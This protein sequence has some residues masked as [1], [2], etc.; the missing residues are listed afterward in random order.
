M[1]KLVPISLGLLIV[2]LCL[3]LQLTT[4]PQIM[5]W[6]HHLANLTYDTQIKFNHWKIDPAK[7]P[8]AIVAID[9]KSLKTIGRWPWDRK[10]L[11]KL[12]DTLYKS[13]AVAV[14]F[15]VVFSEPETN[16]AL[17]IANILEQ[18]NANPL[19]VSSVKQLSPQLAGD[20][21]LGKSLKGGDSILGYIFHA[22]PAAVQNQLPAPLLVLPNNMSNNSIRRM[23]YYSSNI[24]LLQQAAA[25]NGFI[26]VY[27]DPDGIIRRVP[28]LIEHELAL[29]PSLSLAA[30][31]T[32]LLSGVKINW[33]KVGDTW[34]I[35]TVQLG[36]QFIPVDSAGQVLVPYYGKAASFPTYSAGDLLTSK[37]K[38]QSL[39]GKIVFIGATAFGLGDLQTTS[40]DSAFPGVE[41]Q[42]SI[43]YSIFNNQFLVIPA[44]AK[45]LEVV[46]ILVIGILMALAFPYFSPYVSVLSLILFPVAIFFINNLFLHNGI[47]LS[48]VIPNLNVILISILNMAYGYIFEKRRHLELSHIFGQYVPSEY[49]DEMAEHHYE[50]HSEVREMTVLFSDIRNFTTMSEKST[51][52]G[53]AKILNRFFTPMTKIIFQNHGTI[54]KYVGDMIMAFWGAPLSD[55][56][57]RKHALEAALEMREMVTQLHKEFA[58]EGLPTIEIGIGISTGLM[59]VGDMGSE[60]RRAYTVIGDSVNL[61]SRLESLT[62][63]YGANI[64]VSENTTKGQTDFIFRSLGQTH[65]KG[66]EILVNIFELVG[67]R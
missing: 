54:D 46:V 2:L 35:E 64:I 30:V 53:I 8:I 29:Y 11:A 61:G 13:G 57:H 32:Y 67:R 9:D 55:M 45:G 18:Q 34:A 40:I 14:V 23:P 1:K 26:N 12:V 7:N 48:F 37:I 42:A 28:F 36:K 24:P 66:K 59:N 33:E 15:D 31:K 41:I 22:N 16:T 20:A 43:A 44:W 65:V 58:A 47:V 3:W 25:N 62:K 56:D 49:I 5:Q 21:L 51:P 63:E 4:Q 52:E 60:F 10:T 19:A 27:A 6:R 50:M 39:A 38:P 17:V